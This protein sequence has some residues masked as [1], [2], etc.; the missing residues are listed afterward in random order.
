MT[1]AGDRTEEREIPDAPGHTF[2]FRNLSGPEL[3]EADI[4]GTRRMAA[5]ME[6]MPKKTAEAG[7]RD[8]A[9][10]ERD[11]A[12][13]HDWPTLLRYG[14]VAW[15]CPQGASPCGSCHGLYRQACN[16]ENKAKVDTG[17][18]EW[19]ARNIFEMSTQMKGA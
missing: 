1:F 3:D 19:A 12:R 11:E 16:D 4:E 13:E 6:R 7:L 10:H 15:R 2:T 8:D 9:P 5:Q 14:V 18:L 17:T